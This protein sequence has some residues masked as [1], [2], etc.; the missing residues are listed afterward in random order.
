MILRNVVKRK[1]IYK[2]KPLKYI[3][4]NFNNL[5]VNCVNLIFFNL[6]R[7]KLMINAYMVRFYK[8]H[9][10]NANWRL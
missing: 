8:T 9:L 4:Y 3:L 7:R 10:K 1:Q 2:Q 5:T 6:K